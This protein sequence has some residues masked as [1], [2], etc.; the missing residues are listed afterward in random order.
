MKAN[1][2]PADMAVLTCERVLAENI[3]DVATEL[4]LIDVVG[5]VGYIR[6]ERVATLEDLVNSAVELYFKHGALRYAWSADVDLMWE[7]PPSISLNMEFSW[8][9]VNAFFALR[10]DSACAS[11]DLQHIQFDGARDHER[12]GERLAEAMADARAAPPRREAAR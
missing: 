4:R 1:N 3:A 5:L 10:L 12:P 9:G 11:V 8:R 2:M 7:A 6:S